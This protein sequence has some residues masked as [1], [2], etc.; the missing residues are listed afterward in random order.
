[1][2][3]I[4]RRNKK[5]EQEHDKM[6][7]GLWRMLG[8][9]IV[10]LMACSSSAHAYSG[11]TGE[12]NDPYQIA[13]ANALLA[14][15]ATTADYGKC[16]VL[17][18]GIDMEGR[19]FTTAI[20]AHDVDPGNSTFEG[21]AFTGTFDGNGHKVSHFSI[22]GGTNDYLGLFGQ[23]GS[24]GVVSNLG[25]EDFTYSFTTG[26]SYIGGLAG[27]NAGSI[28]GCHSI[29]AMSGG[30]SA[31]RYAGGLV[32]SNTGTVGG[33]YSAGTVSGG[34]AD[35]FL[36]GGLAGS[37]NGTV[38]NCHSTCDVSGGGAIGGLIGSNGAGGSIR[39][40][41]STGTATL[42][43]HGN[44]PYVGGLVASNSGSIR[45]CY[46]TGAASG[47]VA[48]IGGLVGANRSGG[49]ISNCYSTSAVNGS[50][51]WGMGGLAGDNRS[52]SISYCYSAG[53]VTGTGTNIGGLV[54]SGP[55]GS[56][57]FSFWDMTTSGRP[58]STGGTGL[59]TADMKI[60]ATFTS[61][62]WGFFGL[63][64]FG[65]PGTWRM[66]TDGVDYPR[67]TWEH[68]TAGDFACPDGIAMDD[69]ASLAADWL[70]TMRSA[71]GAPAPLTGADATGDAI[72]N[73]LDFT[74]MAAN[75]MQ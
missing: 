62:G 7:L 64:G 42:L 24:G 49:I 17:T 68:V 14:L 51:A 54:G 56:V 16:F 65:A 18:T 66:C 41:Y 2:E 15:A 27:G 22:N 6:S 8:T 32:G 35:S 71:T 69:L 33:C 19:I 1:L 55:G 74:A 47:S 53:A 37:N 13:D 72:V 45:E 23:V 59:L 57:T 31:F 34:A 29:G 30:A 70:M 9:T 50:S 26:S 36:V 28:S 40:C 39:Q 73:F 48:Y 61:A 12:P 3:E 25:V 38:S 52:S 5:Q 63:T 11:G 46:S 67:L 60:L 21:T 75:W 43:F 58:T 10:V 44:S 20:V 4:K